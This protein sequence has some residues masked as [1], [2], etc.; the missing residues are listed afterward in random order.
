MPMANLSSEH[1]SLCSQNHT[2]LMEKRIEYLGRNHD[3]LVEMLNRNVATFCIVV[4]AR[5]ENHISM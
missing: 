3:L 2:I 1:V 5:I 4:I